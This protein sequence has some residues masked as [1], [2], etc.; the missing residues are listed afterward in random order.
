MSDLE[1]SGEDS[2]SHENKA[3]DTSLWRPHTN[4]FTTEF[5]QLL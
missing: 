4:V 5:A 1:A 3:K 2:L